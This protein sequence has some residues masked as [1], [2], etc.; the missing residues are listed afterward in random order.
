MDFPSSYQQIVQRLDQVDPQAYGR[1]RNYL[2]GAVTYL[3]PYIS[4]GVI[5]T[6]QVMDHVFAKG[7][8]PEQ[9]S[10]FIQELAWRDYWQQ[11]WKAKKDAI[12]KDLK[13]TQ[14]PV[15]NHEMPEAILSARTGIQAIDHLIKEFYQTGYLHNHVRMYV[16]AL[17]CNFGQSHWHTPARWMYYH[18]LDA[19]WG[20]NALSWQW[21][22]GSNSNKKYL[23]NQGNI[24]RYCHSD[25]Q[26]TFL[27]QSYESLS[28]MDVPEI[29]E[30]TTMP[31]L[32]VKLPQDKPLE[33]D[34]EKATLGYNFY[35]LDPKWRAEG[36]YNR[37]LLLEPSHFD[38]YPV[39]PKTIDFVL[40]L[41]QNIPK[42]QVLVGEFS[43][44]VRRLGKKEIYYKEHPLNQH[45]EGIEEEREWMFP[46][47]GYYPSFFAF[48]K[49]CKKY[50]KHD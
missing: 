9:I 42:I 4:R 38:Q 24:N 21:V 8:E 40:S 13:T 20:S 39:S 35:N 1:S 2:D 36:G 34:P 46:V 23:A 22:A 10:K 50:L 45:Y 49:Q 18:L 17:A 14:H 12:S 6:R 19:D 5:S 41:A 15:K 48:W 32:G 16:A 7:Y 30:A 47:Q 37:V 26:G 31:D 11:V 29:L 33:V 44:L 28:Q 27:D 25:Q 43:D 3:S